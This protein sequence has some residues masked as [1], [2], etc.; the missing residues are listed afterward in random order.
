MARKRSS[1]SKARSYEAMGEFWDTHDSTDC[2]KLTKPV[3]F[4]VNIQ[5]V[6][7]YFRLENSLAKKLQAIAQMRGVSP[8]TLLNLWVQEH[9][10]KEA[11]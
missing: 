11:A 10:Q 6:T 3:E 4:R 8:E 2:W 1:I 5:S 9:L 7:C